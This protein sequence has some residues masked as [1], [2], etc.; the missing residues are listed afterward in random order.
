ME[1]YKVTINGK[2]YE[3]EVEK[4]EGTTAP[5]PTPAPAPAPAP[6][7]AT[8]ETLKAP[9]QGTVLKVNVQP[10]QSVKAGQVVCVIEAMKLENDIVSDRDGVI[11]E[12]FVRERDTVDNGQE[13]ISFRG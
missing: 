13:L 9:I 4:M 6:S 11:G 1:K 7:A 2:V 8:G 12:I 3:V 5:S 10:G